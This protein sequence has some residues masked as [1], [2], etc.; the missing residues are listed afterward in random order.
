MK[1]TFASRHII[2]SLIRTTLYDIWSSQL[3]ASVAL[4]PNFIAKVII[5]A[6]INNKSIFNRR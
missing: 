5:F 1:S 2:K 3:V 6:N 4:H